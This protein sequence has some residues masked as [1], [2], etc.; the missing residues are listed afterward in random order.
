MKIYIN[1]GHGGADSEAVGT[2][3]QAKGRRTG[4]ARPQWRTS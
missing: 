4:F 2:V 3:R 1:P